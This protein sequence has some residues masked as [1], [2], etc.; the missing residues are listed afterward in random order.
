MT[1]WNIAAV[2]RAVLTL[3]VLSL[4]AACAVEPGEENLKTSF[5]EQIGSVGSVEE[6]QREGDAIRFIERRAD[7]DDVS[8]RVT[9]DS[10]SIVRPGGAPVQGA[11]SASWYAD[12]QLI[13]PIGRMSRLPVAFLEAGVAQE[14][15]AL[16]DD[17]AAA[18][19]W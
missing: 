10:V 15:Y 2:R 1:G 3:A 6:L 18:W 12:G 16:W 11:V 14:C 9:I 19:D 13:E 17:N 8:W 7:G 4:I 5:A